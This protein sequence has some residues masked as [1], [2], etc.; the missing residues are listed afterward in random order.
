MRGLC[1][2]LGQRTLM[3]LVGRVRKK[4]VDFLVLL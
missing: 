1:L 4:A 3:S 2:F